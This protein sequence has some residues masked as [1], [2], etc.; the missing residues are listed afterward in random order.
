MVQAIRIS[1]HPSP[2]RASM[3]RPHPDGNRIA[4]Y[5]AAI[6]VNAALLMLLLVPLRAPPPL[7]APDLI[8][9]VRWILRETPPPQ[10]PLP[11][12]VR[13]PR[14]QAPST[15]APQ[16]VETPPAPQTPVLSEQGELAPDTPDAPL[17]PTTP[18]IATPAATPPGVRLEYA[19]APAP[20]YPRAALHAGIEGTVLLQVL[21]DV[22]GRPLQVDVNRSSGD[23]RLD[24]A[25]R[26]QVLRHWRFRPAIRDGRAVQAIGLV[27]INF[28]LD[29]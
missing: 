10:P 4:G 23:R 27:P 18:A 1:S 17:A 8:Q 24:L 25:A 14:P 7:D 20:S 16:R 3:Q 29:R 26:E 21:V 12:A 15:V 13:K 28:S 9:P 19:R 11:V 22:D 2:S 6:T 5:A